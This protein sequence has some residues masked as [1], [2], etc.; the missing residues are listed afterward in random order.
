MAQVMEKKGSR[1]DLKRTFE[2][3][4]S[5]NPDYHTV[6]Y[7]LGVMEYEAGN[8]NQSR[9]LLVKY[10]K[11]KPQDADAH[12]ILLDIYQKH[13]K[14]KKAF[15][16][17][18]ILVELAPKKVSVYRFIFNYLMSRVDYKQTIS[19]MLKGVKVNP[20][21]VNLREYLAV[22]YLKAGKD[23][24]AVSQI[25]KILKVKPGQVDLLLDL[26]KLKEKRGNFTGALEVCKR[27]LKIAPDN[28]EAADYYLRLRL[29]AVKQ[30]EK[31]PGAD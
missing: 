3:I 8:F 27:V 25:E 29:K 24:L 16:E 21:Q 2:K 6:L 11:I 4:L 12:E 15:E 18:R 1:K 17:A 22:A 5:I 14:L 9:G 28:E 20:E 13:K 30:K 19:F 10:I 23:T 31:V 26:A 7:N